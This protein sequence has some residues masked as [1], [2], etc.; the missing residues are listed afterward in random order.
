MANLSQYS[1]I[2]VAT[3]KTKNNV[4]TS[5]NKSN[6]KYRLFNSLSVYASS[7]ENK[8]NCLVGV[9]ENDNL[10]QIEFKK[11]GSKK[12]PKLNIQS[13]NQTNRYILITYADYDVSY[14]YDTQF[15]HGEH[16]RTY[17]IDKETNLVFKLDL[18]DHFT[19]GM[20]G[21]GIIGSD[22]GDTLLIQANATY[23]IG[24]ENNELKVQEIFRQDTIFDGAEIRLADRYGNC[25]I[26]RY[27]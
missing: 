9:D 18:F 10:E 1:N 25:I 13:Y 6:S 27:N 22:C 24:V 11:D 19:V 7:N 8:K 26:K 5:N 3:Y 15:W 17:L 16:N 23:R 12:K 4:R 20:Y 14:V 2:G 21:Y